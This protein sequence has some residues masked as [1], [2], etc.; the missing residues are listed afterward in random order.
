MRPGTVY[1]LRVIPI[2]AA[3]LLLGTSPVEARRQRPGEARSRAVASRHR[4][5]N[6]AAAAS[7]RAEAGLAE[8]RSARE[9]PPPDRDQ[10]DFVGQ[11]VGDDEVPGARHATRR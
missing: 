7:A 3:L 10:L 2:V 8:L 6:E 1:L 4:A 5:Q 11:Q 9:L